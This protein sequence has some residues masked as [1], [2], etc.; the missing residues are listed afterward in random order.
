M[1]ISSISKGKKW[2]HHRLKKV[3][4]EAKSEKVHTIVILA[5]KG[6]GPGC[7]AERKELNVLL[8][9]LTNTAVQYREVDISDALAFVQPEAIRPF[10]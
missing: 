3:L 4:D 2:W 9:A 1:P 8:G 6:G 10:L 5:I 7:E